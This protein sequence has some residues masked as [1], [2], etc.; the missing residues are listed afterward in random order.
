[1]MYGSAMG[2]RKRPCIVVPATASPQPTSAAVKTRG[3]RTS[4]KI[5][6]VFGEERRVFRG[7]PAG[8]IVTAQPTLMIRAQ[9]SV[10]MVSGAVL[11]IGMV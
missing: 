7:M 2:F 3:R 4:Q 5:I 10:R 9:T 11:R 6:Q 1:M 8:P